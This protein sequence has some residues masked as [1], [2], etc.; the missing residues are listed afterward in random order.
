MTEPFQRLVL[1]MVRWPE[2]G[3]VKTRLA[4]SIGNAEACLIHRIMAEACFREAVAVRDARVVVCGTG[5]PCASFEDWLRGA[6]DYW[7][8]PEG[9]LGERLEALH[10]RAFREG[11]KSVA[12]IGSDAPTLTAADIATALDATSGGRV[13]LLPAADGGYVLIAAASHVPDL[14]GGIPWGTDGVLRATLDACGR[15]GLAT[16][17][18]P[19]HRDVDT[20]DDWRAVSAA[21]GLEVPT[22]PDHGAPSA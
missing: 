6:S 14:F 19:V 18:G 4:L 1:F 15:L 12:A 11:A 10:G 2:P 17:V 8:Q 22:N 13:S 9:D 7:D 20:L 3:R 21:C 5:A 16:H